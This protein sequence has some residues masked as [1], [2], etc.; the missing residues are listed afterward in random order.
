MY[1]QILTL[2]RFSSLL[3]CAF[4]GHAQVL[5]IIPAFEI[6]RVNYYH[7][8]DVVLA[9]TGNIGNSQTWD[10]SN[11]NYDSQVWESVQRDLDANEFISFPDANIVIESNGSIGYYYQSPDSIVKVGGYPP[12]SSVEMSYT[13]FE[14][15]FDS[16]IQYN[17]VYTDSF[18]YNYY[19][20][21]VLVTVEGISTWVVSAQGELRTPTMIYPNTYKLTRKANMQFYAQGGL[22]QVV[23]AT[24][25]QWLDENHSSAL[26]E[27]SHDD[28]NNTTSGHFLRNESFASLQKH[29][30]SKSFAYP[31]PN[32]GVFNILFDDHQ[33]EKT[34]LTV[35]DA[36]GNIV[37]EEQFDEL[38]AFRKKEL[39][40][41]AYASGTYTVIIRSGDH[42][43]SQRVIVQ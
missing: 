30:S 35:I 17:T 22:V 42:Q 13:N 36:T 16:T 43:K 26:M 29:E 38:P 7:N 39:D 4:P 40:L 41:S 8:I 34:T 19:S 15:F 31:N 3:I 9:D 21:A 14:T 6:G 32:N 12:A 28:Y 25:T 24:N 1:K 2:L 18:S 11:H 5:D 27:V 37:L 33:N 10:F 23:N 20:G